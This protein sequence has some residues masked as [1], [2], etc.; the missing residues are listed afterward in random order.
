MS[1][2]DNFDDA[3]TALQDVCT[4]IY[5]GARY[6]LTPHTLVAADVA[7][8]VLGFDPM[9][10]DRRPLNQFAEE[11]ER[12]Y[13]RE[14]LLDRIGAGFSRLDKIAD[15]TLAELNLVSRL[16]KGRVFIT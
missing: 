5:L 9:T 15:E 4:G 13:G 12:R 10:G 16:G 6:G 14:H 3:A 8:D 1:N 2:P 11:I 7:Q